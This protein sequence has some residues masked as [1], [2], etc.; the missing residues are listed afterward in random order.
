MEWMVRFKF[1]Y[2]SEWFARFRY[3]IPMSEKVS[4]D[5]KELMKRHQFNQK[6]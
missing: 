3:L 1:I 6:R 5:R 2:E 4:I